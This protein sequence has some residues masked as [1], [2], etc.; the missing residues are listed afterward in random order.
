M[1]DSA[2]FAE[3]V[4]TGEESDGLIFDLKLALRALSV[5]DKARVRANPRLT[6]QDGREAT[7][8]IGEE[9]YYSLLS[10]SAA[11]PYFTL[12]KI[13]TGISLRIVPYVGRNGEITTD[14]ELLVSDVAGVGASNLPVTTVRSVNTEVLVSNGQTIGIGGL[15]TEEKREGSHGIPFLAD[16]PILGYLFGY[17]TWTTEETEVVVLI[18]PHILLDPREFDRL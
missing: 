2:L 7:I 3:M 12:E 16:I 18:T 11:Y 1:V 13:E 9:A 15:V 6:T 14:I 10:G 4:K 5:K 8:R 17:N